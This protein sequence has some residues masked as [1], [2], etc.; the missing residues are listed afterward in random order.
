MTE[1][2]FGAEQIVKR[3]SLY[4][5]VAGL[6]PVPL[7]DIAAITGVQL[8]MLSE[9]AKNYGVPFYQEQGKAIVSALLGSII[10]TKLGFGAAGS[11]LKGLPVVGPV[12]GI[13]TT[14]IFGGAATWAVGKV[15]IQH[16]ASGGTF[17]DF[18]PD[19]VRSYFQSEY[20]KARASKI[21][22]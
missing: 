1:K 21:V 10:P 7:V 15:F 6:V 11:L 8:K 13:F 22:A 3:Y 4:S 2:D 14:S 9:L 19:K 12:L 16:F 5:G 18:D 17:L 20:D